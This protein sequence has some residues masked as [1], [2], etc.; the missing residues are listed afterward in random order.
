MCKN[1]F[2]QK[3]ASNAFKKKCHHAIGSTYPQNWVVKFQKN[4]PQKPSFSKNL[5]IAG[6]K[7]CQR[8]NGFFQQN[9]LNRR[10]TKPMEHYMLF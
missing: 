7:V 2:H 6:G 3:I 9:I 10:A 1:I 5:G 8:K 4:F